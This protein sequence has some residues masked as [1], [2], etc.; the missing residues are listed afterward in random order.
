MQNAY[1]LIVA[2]LAACVDAPVLDHEPQARIL[3]SWDPLACG[4]P[5]RVVIEL[6]DLDGRKLS[7][8]VP[9]E[10][11]GV[12]V[13][14]PQ[15]GVYLGRI[16]AWSVGPEIRSIMHVRIDVDASVILWTVETP[17]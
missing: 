13:D 11:G 8:S 5:H 9:C 1:G 3:A 16:Y 4:D 6:E 10:T 12:T 17:R 2:A 14:V 7:R 15:W